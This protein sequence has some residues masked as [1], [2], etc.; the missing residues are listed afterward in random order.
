MVKKLNITR[1]AA[2]VGLSRETLYGWKRDGMDLADKK[3]V[4]KRAR[5]VHAAKAGLGD[6]QAARLAKLQAEAAIKQHEERRL[7]GEFVLR[8][9]VEE[10]FVKLGAAGNAALHRLA[11]DLPPMLVGL[12]ETQMVPVI[13]A[14]IDQVSAAIADKDS[15]AWA[16]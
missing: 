4:V 10:W 15:F 2:E 13:R 14:A 5:A 1:L 11:V 8:S 9:E 3:A 16:G 6:M 7:R 12:N